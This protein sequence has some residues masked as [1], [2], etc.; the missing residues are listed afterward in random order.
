MNRPNPVWCADIIWIPMARGVVYLVAV[1]DGYSRKVLSWRLSNTIDSHFCVEALEEALPEEPL[2]T[3]SNN[4]GPLL[5]RFPGQQNPLYKWKWACRLSSP[6]AAMPSW[7][8]RSRSMRAP[9]Q[10]I[11]RCNRSTRFIGMA[12][13]RGFEPLLPP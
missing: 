5:A 4:W 3:L 12:S 9:A 7:V 6:G 13:P 10:G 11:S 8:R 1:M 2:S